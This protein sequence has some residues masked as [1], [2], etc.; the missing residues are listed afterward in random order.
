MKRNPRL[1]SFV[2]WLGLLNLWNADGA[3]APVL[4][5]NTENSSNPLSASQAIASFRIEKGFGVELAAAEPT[6]IDPVAIAFD[7]KGRM[8]VVEDRGYPTGPPEGQPPVGVVALLEDTDG[9]GVYDKRTIF[10]D[11]LTFPNGI[12]CWRGGVFV[13]CAPDIYYFKDTL[14]NGRANVRRVVLTGFDDTTTT[15]LRVSHPTLGLDGWIYLTSGLTGGKVKSPEHPERPAVEFKKSDSRFRPDTLEFETVSGAGQFGMSFDQFGRRFVCSNRNPLQHIVLETRYLR[16]NP[17]LAFSETVQDVAPAGAAAK[18][19]PISPDTTTASFIP[20]LMGSPHA[21]TFTSA[22]GCLIYRGDMLGPGFSGNAF[23]CEPAQNLVQRQVL[24]PAGATFRAEPAYQGVDFLTSPDTWFRP[25]FAADGPEDALYICDMYRKVIDHP[26]YLPEAIRAISD[27]DAGKD[28]GRIYRIVPD[29]MLTKDVAVARFPKLSDLKGRELCAALTNSNGWR[30][31][32]AFRLLLERSD[33]STAPALRAMT[34]DWRLLPQTRVAALRLLDGLNQLDL[35]TIELALGDSHAGVRENAVQLA[36][37]R[38]NDSRPLVEQVSKLGNDPEPRVRFQCALAL[39]EVARSG[40]MDVLAGIALRDGADPWARAA[41][42][43]SV[44]NRTEDFFNALVAKPPV[45]EDAMAAVMTDL[46]HI[47]GLGQPPEKCLMLLNQITATVQNIGLTWQAAAVEGLA[48]GLRSR[49]LAHA[50]LSSIQSLFSTDSAEA[51]LGRTRFEELLRHARNQASR[52]DTPPTQRLAAI[53][54]LGEADS[55][56]AGSLLLSLIASLEPTEVQTTAVRACSRL[57]D[58]DLMKA[59]VVGER[60]RGYLPPAREAVLSVLMSQRGNFS[61][62]LD[63]LERGDIQAW[64]IDPARRRQ[65]M[66]DKDE[67]IK[68]RALALFKGQE[69]GDRQEVYENCKSVLNLS[70]DSRNG[71]QVFKRICAQCHTHSG[72]G[73]AVGPDLTGVSNQPAEALLL[74]ILIPSYEIVPGYTSYDVETKDGQVLTGLIASETATTITL[75]RA[76]GITDSI[77]RSNIAKISSGG[78]SLMP[79][80]LEKTMT[81]QELADLIAFLKTRRD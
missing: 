14:G 48:E 54:L 55:A 11:G 75:K 19:W 17:Y 4:P 40:E 63:A 50:S 25:V 2:V 26:Q 44:G 74:H 37:A 59:L 21:G 77:L 81:R 67:V 38:L 46:S 27:F 68:K 49:G 79:D 1:C 62:I 43:S 9:D 80:E 57:Q 34:S 7:E 71:H 8:Y 28:K 10:A 29:K 53:A 12:V 78:L 45:S 64:C 15:Q 60:W 36:E 47:F 76:L 65:L 31:A 13:T 56:N 30:R 42:L 33:Q 20:E 18:V 32:T 72:E 61:V 41:V 35:K 3:S 73:V 51:R 6:T 23:V 24:S 58:P 70:T 5:T 52:V 22:C 16:R 39:G 66:Q 69:S